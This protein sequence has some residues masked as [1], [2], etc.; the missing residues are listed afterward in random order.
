MDEIRAR[1]V[2]KARISD[3][4]SLD[5]DHE[6]LADRDFSKR[7]LRSLTAVGSRFR[8]CR[9]ERMKIDDA[10]FGAGRE[11]S[12]YIE[13]SFDGSRIIAP[14]PGRARFVRCSFREV[15]LKDWFCGKAEFIECTFSGRGQGLIF[16]GTPHG[17][18]A[19]QMGR[20][21]NEF[22]DN[23]FKAMDLRDSAFRGGIDL[24]KQ[25]LPTGDH[26]LLLTEAQRSVIAARAQ[27]SGWDDDEKRERA[28]RFLRGL[29]DDIEGG[30]EQLFLRRDDYTTG[31]QKA[32]D[33]LF[34]ILRGVGSAE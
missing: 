20:S 15:R 8:R 6:D 17:A 33:D 4:D 28:L 29:V 3:N 9:F 7:R 27:V 30:Q 24:T 10:G 2:G 26:Y 11:V 34:E 21:A 14:A 5:F 23:D 12:E 16:W 25:R 1:V 13:C 32:L 19:E 22:R 31:D 18:S